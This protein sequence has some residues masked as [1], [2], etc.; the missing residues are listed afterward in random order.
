MGLRFLIVNEIPKETKPNYEDLGKVLPY[1]LML[2]LG[3]N[4]EGC[5]RYTKSTR[6]ITN[7]G[8]VAED[9]LEEGAF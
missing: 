7:S 9:F 5:T 1:N 6:G 8:R 2:Q 4:I 3:A